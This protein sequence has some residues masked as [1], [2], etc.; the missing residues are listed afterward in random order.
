MSDS[1][2]ILVLA[3]THVATLQ[4]LPD[5]LRQLVKET[6]YVVHCGDF[7]EIRVVEELRS[8]AKRFIGVYGNTDSPEIRELL[9][10]EAFLEIHGKR[11]AVTHP[12]FGGPPW[13]LEEE[14]VERYPI[15]DVILFGHTHDACSIHKNGTLLFNPGQGYPMF[16]QQAS[17]GIL[18]VTAEGIEGRISSMD[19]AILF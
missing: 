1:I 16:I 12:Y 10:T 6:D 17:V 3:D 15:A 19:N 11:I 2:Y 7:T 4:Q 9:P 18:K 14:L 8:L 13:G 5:R